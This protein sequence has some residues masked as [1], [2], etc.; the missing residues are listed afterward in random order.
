VRAIT[1]LDLDLIQVE[2]GILY[3]ELSHGGDVK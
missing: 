2:E 1:K 3:T